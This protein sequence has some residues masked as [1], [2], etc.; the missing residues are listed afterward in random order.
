MEF[1]EKV[2]SERKRMGITLEELSE[3]TQVSRSMLSKIEREEKNPTIQ[4]AA[5]I[6]EGMG[7]TISQLLGEQKQEEVVI[8]RKHQR[9]MYKDPD[10]GFERH[11]L[12]PSVSVKGLEFILN[13]VPPHQESGVFPSHKQG[14]DEYIFVA[15]GSLQ[16]ELENGKKDYILEQGDSMYFEADKNHR[17]LNLSDKECQYYLI[18]DSR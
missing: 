5:Q 17:F 9:L 1:G 4:I 14:V 11:L 6:A 13:I 2:K 3:R 15:E 8:I 12:S 7:V 16:V 18:I 10:S